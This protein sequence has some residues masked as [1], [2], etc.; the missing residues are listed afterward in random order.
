MLEQVLD[1]AVKLTAI[2]GGGCGAFAA[3]YAAFKSR[4]ILVE[5][6][7]GNG[8][9]IAALLGATETRR[10]EKIPV[11]ERTATEAEHVL[12]VDEKGEAVT[13]RP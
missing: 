8:Q 3:I 13:P 6:R 12:K 1:V 2:I 10:V 4:S 5:V 9:T 11:D 7:A